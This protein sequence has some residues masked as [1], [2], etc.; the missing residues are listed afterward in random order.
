MTIPEEPDIDRSIAL[1]MS[2]RSGV[3]YRLEEDADRWLA[4]SRRGVTSMSAKTDYLSKEQ[5]AL[6]QSKEVMNH[7]GVSDASLFSGMYR[8]AYNPQAGQ[9]PKGRRSSDDA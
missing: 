9:R 1:P 8:R 4:E 5:L 6:R 7:H 3:D 2:L